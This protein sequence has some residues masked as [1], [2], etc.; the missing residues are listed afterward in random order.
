M[1]ADNIRD[2][3][4][5]QSENA[6]EDTGMNIVDDTGRINIVEDVNAAEVNATDKSSLETLS[7]STTMESIKQPIEQ[8]LDVKLVFVFG[9]SSF[10]P[11]HLF[12]IYKLGQQSVCA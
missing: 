11:W 12:P 7:T 4:I 9:T 5:E 10:T 8:M 1:S 3:C 6:S 2:I